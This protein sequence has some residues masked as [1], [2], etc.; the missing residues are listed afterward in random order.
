MEHPFIKNIRWWEKPL[1]FELVSV[2]LKGGGAKGLAYIGALEAMELQ[3]CWFKAV[4]GAS[5]GALTALTIAAGLKLREIKEKMDKV[6][7]TLN[8]GFFVPFE[9]DI[10]PYLAFGPGLTFT[11]DKVKFSFGGGIAYGSVNSIA[12]RF[13]DVDVTSVTDVTTLSEK[14]GTVVGM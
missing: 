5:A 1:K 11:G 9:E 10:T 4:A 14:Y 7:P 2:V 6:I 8:L 12:E 13:V 3:E